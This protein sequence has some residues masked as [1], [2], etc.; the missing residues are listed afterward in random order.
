LVREIEHRLEATFQG[1][2]FVIQALGGPHA[3]SIV[4]PIL[5]FLGGLEHR[6]INWR[7]DPE[8]VEMVRT[9][10]GMI[11]DAALFNPLSRE[12]QR[13]IAIETLRGKS[14]SARDVFAA[15]LTAVQMLGLAEDRILEG[16]S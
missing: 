9:I 13:S 6:G 5:F 7:G 1:P 15:G 10:I 12:K 4:R 16:L 8:L 14:K 2:E 11:V 3:E